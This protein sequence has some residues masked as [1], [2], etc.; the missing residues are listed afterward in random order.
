VKSAAGSTSPRVTSFSTQAFARSVRAGLESTE[1]MDVELRSFRW[2]IPF[3][4]FFDAPPPMASCGKVSSNETLK[5]QPGV[6][7]G[8]Q[9]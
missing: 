9:L 2:G 6:E 1:K 8:F 3:R 4:L 5:L 7:K